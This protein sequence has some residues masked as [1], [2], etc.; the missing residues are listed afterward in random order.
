MGVSSNAAYV[1]TYII[2]F[3]VGSNIPQI[4]KLWKLNSVK[5]YEDYFWI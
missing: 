1:L 5:M 4:N 2:L 3:H